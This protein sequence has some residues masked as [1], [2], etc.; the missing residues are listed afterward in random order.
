MDS[1]N[2]EIIKWYS[3]QLT[4]HYFD[5]LIISMLLQYK[6]RHQ[7]GIYIASLCERNGI[8]PIRVYCV[9]SN[10]KSYLRIM[11]IQRIYPLHLP[12]WHINQNKI[13]EEG[14]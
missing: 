14:I 3:Y 10:V 2:T 6:I 8:N 5:A 13:D 4:M 9:K 12:Q 7:F 1:I 11:L